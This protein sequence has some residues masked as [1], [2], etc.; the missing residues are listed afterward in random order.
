MK[1]TSL[2]SNTKQKVELCNTEITA[3]MKVIKG[4]FQMQNK[5][6]IAETIERHDSRENILRIITII[7]Y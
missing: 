1:S 3:A 6:A 7:K 5:A 4:R 2:T